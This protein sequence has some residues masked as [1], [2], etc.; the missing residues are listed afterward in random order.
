MGLLWKSKAETERDARLEETQRGQAS[1]A[2]PSASAWVSANAGTGKTHV[3][4]GVAYAV[5]T[6]STFLK[7]RAPRARRVLVVDG[8]MP[9]SELRERLQ[10]INGGATPTPRTLRILPVDMIERGIGTLACPEVQ[11]ELDP[12]LAGVELLVLDNL[13]SLTAALREND[14]D[15]WSPIQD[16][17][18][19]L[20]RRGISVLIVHHAGKTGGQR[21]T[22]RREDVRTRDASPTPRRCQISQSQ[23]LRSQWRDN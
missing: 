8:E 13:S 16:W 19:R 20:R 3:A 14:A 17:L 21:G 9:A 11:A 12:W 18:L 2:D 15:S 6:G 23:G 10:W 7:W 1:A 5:A 22:S 4:L